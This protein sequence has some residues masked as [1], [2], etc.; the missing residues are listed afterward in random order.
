MNCEASEDLDL[1]VREGCLRFPG[2]QIL[3]IRYDVNYTNTITSSENENYDAELIIPTNIC[4]NNTFTLDFFTVLH[5]PLCVSECE[6]KNP[7]SSFFMSA[8]LF[9]IRE[10]LAPFRTCFCYNWRNFLTSENE[11]RFLLMSLLQ[12][13]IGTVRITRE[14]LKR[15]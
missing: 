10:F 3:F 13:K 1:L 11:S 8:A 9:N 15:S 7:A 12:K 5:S 4:Q 14:E 6:Q 2:L